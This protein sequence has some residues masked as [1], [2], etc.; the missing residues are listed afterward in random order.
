MHS[1]R[2]LPVSNIVCKRTMNTLEDKH[3]TVEPEESAISATTAASL[4]TTNAAFNAAMAGTISAEKARSIAKEAVDSDRVLLHNYITVFFGSLNGAI[5]IKLIPNA[6]RSYFGLDIHNKN[7][8]DIN[9]DEKMTEWANRIL[10]GDAERVSDGGFVINIPSKVSF[11]AVFA[12]N[13]AS[14]NALSIA[15]S[16]VSKAQATVND[17]R[18]A[19]DKLIKHAWNE[20]ENNFSDLLA[21]ALRAASR[22]WSVR[23][24]SNG[25]PLNIT[26]KCTDSETGLP[27]PDVT[28]HL[29]GIA[30]KVTNDI[31]G[32]YKLGTSQYGDM[33]LIAI[34]KDYH[35][36]DI[37]ITIEN[38]VDLVVNVIMTHL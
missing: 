27:V 22:P 25:D 7:L 36:A 13:K 14:L 5:L 26:G 4:T 16:A 19:V 31:A 30:N 20:V 17:L 11:T 18:P 8:P 21:P 23:Y 24:T 33:V 6:A 38:G 10:I 32:N 34:A 9:T 12:K 2:K 1:A 35:E 29:E 37:S 28:L 15:V 3:N